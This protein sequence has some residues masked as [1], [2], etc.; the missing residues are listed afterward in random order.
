MALEVITQ[1]REPDA[2][3]TLCLDLNAHSS[4]KGL[5]RQQSHDTTPSPPWRV[6]LDAKRFLEAPDLLEGNGFEWLSGFRCIEYMGIILV[7]LSGGYLCLTR[8]GKLHF[9]NQFKN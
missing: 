8:R 2:R 7:V 5:Q 9:Y 1:F 4:H 6:Q 3:E